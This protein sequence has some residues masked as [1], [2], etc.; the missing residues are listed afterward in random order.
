VLSCTVCVSRSWLLVGFM[1]SCEV[2]CATNNLRKSLWDNTCDPADAVLSVVICEAG[3]EL[4]MELTGIM[5][6]AHDSQPRGVVALVDGFLTS[7]PERTKLAK[8]PGWADLSSDCSR[9]DC[10]NGFAFPPVVWSF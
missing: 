8:P 3:V 7:E 6:Q 10:G 9:P 1:G 2:I 4:D 5:V